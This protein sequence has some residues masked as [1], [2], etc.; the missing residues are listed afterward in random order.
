[1]L[2]RERSSRAR[3]WRFSQPAHAWI[4]G[5]LLRAWNGNF[6]EPLL[7]AAEQHDIGWMD[8]ETAPSFNPATGRPHLFREI[9]ASVHA[10]MWRRGGAAGARRLGI[11]C[12]AAD[13]APWRGDLPAL[14]RSSPRRPRPMRRRRRPSGRPGSDRGRM[15]AR[16][17]TG[18]CG[19]EPGVA[20]VAAVDT[21]SLALCGELKTPLELEAPDGKG[22]FVTLRL[23]ERPEHP[24]E[25][26]LSPWPFRT[27]V[28]HGGRR[29][30]GRSRPPDALPMKRRCRRGCQRRNRVTFS[31][32][33]MSAG[34]GV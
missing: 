2:F 14:Y 10:P 1:M 29:G 31:A 6:A 3:R 8:W 18:I 21:L 12:G 28:V 13:L 15:G 26:V 25:F 20:L 34:G 24:F 27:A 9:G 4:S 7:L 17:R 5:Q 33:L 32:R 11:A 22:G 19:A 16:P 30:G 23:A